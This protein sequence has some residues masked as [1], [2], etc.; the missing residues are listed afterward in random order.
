MQVIGV[1][2]ELNPMHDG[3]RYLLKTIRQ[4]FPQDI[5][6]IVL[7]T[8]FSSR[9]L[10]SLQTPQVKTKYALEAGADLVI[11][12]PCAY[13]LQSADYF[14]LYAIEAL[15]TAGVNRLCFGSERACLEVLE[16][17]AWKSSQ[18]KIN[19]KISQAQNV[20]QANLA[21]QPNDILALAYIRYATGFGIECTPI[22][23]NQELKSATQI[24][25]DYFQGL[26][27]KQEDTFQSNQRL[28]NYYPLL[29]YLLIQSDPKWL[30]SLFLV[31]EGIEHRL[32][33]AALV[34][35]TWPEFLKATI[36][37]TY[38]KARIQ[39]TCMMI[40]LQISKKEMKKHSS[41]FALQ[42]LGMNERGRSHLKTLPIGT[43]IY[44]R[45]RELP[46]WLQT[47]EL[48]A[49]R[50]YKLFSSVKGWEVVVL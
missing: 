14:A 8:W 26:F 31:E 40:L 22:L 44:T 15:K 46:T 11:A 36:S 10:P 48:K 39:R 49:F 9:G 29:R 28:E 33:K 12:L 45:F 24:R 16:V 1:I 20:S 17:D 35:E 7:S 19:P 34:H 27:Q 41:F 21:Q 30:S 37:K 50:L 18:L 13:T 4:K 6:V 2:A 25:Q 3:H 42:L 43:P 47:L 23:R 5:V 32:I 38:T